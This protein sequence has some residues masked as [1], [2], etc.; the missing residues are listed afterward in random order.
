MFRESLKEGQAYECADEAGCVQAVK[1]N[2][3]SVTRTEL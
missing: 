2:I 3:D 1:S